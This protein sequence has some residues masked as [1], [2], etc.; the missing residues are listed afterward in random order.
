MEANIRPQR[1]ILA[2]R[3]DAP[4]RLLGLSRS[5]DVPMISLSDKRFAI[6]HEHVFLGMG[7]ERNECE[8]WAV[9][10]LCGT[11][12]IVGGRLFGSPRLAR[13]SSGPHHGWNPDTESLADG[14]HDDRHSRVLPNLRHDIRTAH[15][16]EQPA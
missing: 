14:N 7:H 11:V 8:T 15:S 12:M 4:A 3:H 10:A 2:E 6:N 13:R 5:I 1:P 16:R 9:I